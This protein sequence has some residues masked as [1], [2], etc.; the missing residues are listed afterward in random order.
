M[1]DSTKYSATIMI[2]EVEIHKMK[3]G[4]KHGSTYLM[5]NKIKINSTLVTESDE[6]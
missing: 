4:V 2:F 1:L 6:I 3:I 5:K